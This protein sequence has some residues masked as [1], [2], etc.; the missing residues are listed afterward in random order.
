MK[1]LGPFAAVAAAPLLEYTLE[2]FLHPVPKVPAE[3]CVEQRIDARI[4]VG[5]Q[6]G[7]RREEGV[8]I[9]VS[10]V[11]LGPESTRRF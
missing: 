11:V 1:A 2:H 5:D 4:E 6:K 8:E 7:Q 9:G 10:P 3:K